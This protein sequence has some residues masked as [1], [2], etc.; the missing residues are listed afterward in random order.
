[1]GLEDWKETKHYDLDRTAQM[2][3]YGQYYTIH[4]SSNQSRLQWW[5]TINRQRSEQN[6]LNR[7]KETFG[8]PTQVVI[9]YGNW[10]PSRNT[11]HQLPFMR[12]G[13]RKAGYLVVLVDEFRTSA[14][15]YNCECEEGKCVT[16]HKCKNPRPR[17]RNQNTYK[18][19]I[20]RHGLVKCTKCNG[21]WNRDKNSSLNILRIMEYHRA[22]FRRPAYLR[23]H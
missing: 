23:R 7:F 10:C 1:M 8:D 6:M 21:F 14:R 9:G 15:C 13:L 19:V 17:R 18:E 2:I 3:S 11:R 20:V 22:G 4:R 16:F 12:K 5:A